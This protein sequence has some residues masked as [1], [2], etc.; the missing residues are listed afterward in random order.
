LAKIYKFLI[1][2][3]DSTSGD[4]NFHIKFH[5]CSIQIQGESNSL[6]RSLSGKH[7]KE[8]EE[9]KSSLSD[10]V[11]DL[12]KA[13][14]VKTKDDVI[15]KGSLTKLKDFVEEIG[16]EN[17]PRRKF[18]NGLSFAARTVKNIIDTYNK[19]ASWAGLQ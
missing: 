2:A 14:D 5:N 19:I 1:Y 17:S 8:A 3:P 18:I 9:L 7:E 15:K 11:S 16:D 4:I 6:I 10:I 12:E 13:E